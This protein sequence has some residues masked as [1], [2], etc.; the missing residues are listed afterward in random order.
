MTW[1]NEP[2]DDLPPDGAWYWCRRKQGN[3]RPKVVYCYRHYKGYTAIAFQPL[4]Q[5]DVKTLDY[6]WAGPIPE[7]VSH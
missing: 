1:T 6:E 3:L 7:P 2:P 4:D 5:R